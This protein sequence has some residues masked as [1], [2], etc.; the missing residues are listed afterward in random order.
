MILI[1]TFDLLPLILFYFIKFFIIVVLTK[2]FI[3]RKVNI[4][5]S[6]KVCNLGP[7]LQLKYKNSSFLIVTNLKILVS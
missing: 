1:D 2:I 6:C 3:F 5:F 4:I 7:Y